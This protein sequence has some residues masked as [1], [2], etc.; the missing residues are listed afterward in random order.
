MSE[1]NENPFLKETQVHVFSNSCEF[2][3]WQTANCHDCVKYEN[4]SSDESEAKCKLAYHL[5]FGAILGTIP[6]WVCKEIGIRYDPLYQTG[7]ISATC[8]QRQ[9]EGDPF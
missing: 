3:S 1:F 9:R 8:R 4:E 5:D 6:L 7:Q 2:D